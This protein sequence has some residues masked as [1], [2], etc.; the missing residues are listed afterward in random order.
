MTINIA[1]T[2]Y[3]RRITNC[4]PVINSVLENTLVPDRIYLTLSHLE[5][6][7]YEQSL[8]IDLY[9][10]IM[11]S[12]KVILNWVE[13]N[14]KSMK[15]VFPILPYLEDE[16][17]IIDIDDDM[18]LPKDFIESRIRDFK[19]YGCKYPITSNL[20]KTMNIDSLVMSAY[21]LMQK[22][23]LNGYEKFVTKEILNTF[24][25]DRTYLYLMYMNGYE[26]K[27]CTKYSVNKV[28]GIQQLDISPRSG[29]SYTVGQE[30][31]VVVDS[32]VRKISN[33]RSI[34]E[35]FGLFNEDGINIEHHDDIKQK[36]KT[37]IERQSEDLSIKPI[38]GIV[39]D[40]VI[41]KFSSV[42]LDIDKLFQYNL[43][44]QSSMIWYMFQEKEV[45]TITLK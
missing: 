10:L 24:N 4:V 35:C 20:S 2:S 33:G 43:K 36:P 23:M 18:I 16:D 42:E 8:P 17:V 15:K 7:N 9:R 38:S 37:K 22:K 45:R 13:D 1:L 26:L 11:T 41:S 30:Y 25:D 39:D 27:P 34:N 3:P 19:N 14:Y 29:Y 44:K 6:P 32:V 5:F 12:N 31:D 40:G 28:N 21:S